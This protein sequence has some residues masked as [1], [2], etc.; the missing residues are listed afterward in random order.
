[1]PGVLTRPECIHVLSDIYDTQE[2]EVLWGLSEGASEYVLEYSINKP[3]EQASAGRTWE[4]IANDQKMW[5]QIHQPEY[6]W[7]QIAA[8]SSGKEFAIYRGSGISTDIGVDT[9]KYTWFGFHNMNLSWDLF[10]RLG[11]PEDVQDNS[12]YLL[13][14]QELVGDEV[15]GQN[16]NALDGYIR[17]WQQMDDSGVFSWDDF[18]LLLSERKP[19]KTY[20]SSALI[21]DWDLDNSFDD[22]RNIYFRAKADDLNQT[23]SE[24]ITSQ[25]HYI[26][27]KEI[28]SETISKDDEYLLQIDGESV[29]D[30]GST[31]FTVWYD[32]STLIFE[33]FVPQNNVTTKL[34]EVT[35]VKKSSSEGYISFVCKTGSDK[36]LTKECLIVKLKFKVT[37]SNNFQL[38]LNRINIGDERVV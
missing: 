27:S 7:I 38:E 11:K 2:P 26:I 28:F 24:Y 21:R 15:P 8:L 25:K 17:T 10:H 18:E 37:V 12:R 14:W 19:H 13:A 33:G 16:W 6:S 22:N 4:S 9:G 29:R 3:F 30:V 1:M 20:D 23:E 5:G 32:P 35:A 31:R 34:S 36:S